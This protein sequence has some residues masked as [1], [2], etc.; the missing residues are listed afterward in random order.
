[1]AQFPEVQTKARAEQQAFSQHPLTLES[2]KHMTYLDQVMQ[3][4]LRLIPPVGGAFRDVIQTCEYG[5]YQIPADWSIL[6]G[7]NVTHADPET[8]SKPEQFDPERF[9]PER[10][11]DKAKPFS[12]VPFG[13]GL[14]ECL[15]K[16][17]ARLEMRLFGANTA[18]I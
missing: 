4:V 2:L 13:G 18:G 11:E 6:Y 10:A 16:E 17:F 9:D 12:H 15:G 8:F 7:I 5:G 1:M 14:R 3:E